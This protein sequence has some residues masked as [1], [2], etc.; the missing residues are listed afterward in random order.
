MFDLLTEYLNIVLV[1]TQEIVNKA[2]ADSHVFVGKAPVEAIG[3]FAASLVRHQR[4][5]ADDLLTYPFGFFRKAVV[6]RGRVAGQFSFTEAAYLAARDSR[7]ASAGEEAKNEK[8]MEKNS[9]PGGLFLLLVSW[10]IFRLQVP[11]FVDHSQHFDEIVGFDFVEN[12]VGV[13]A[14]FPH[15]VFIQFRHFASFAGQDVQADGFVHQL[16]T[17]AP[18]IEWGVLG[19]VIMNM[20]K[21]GFGV[22]RPLHHV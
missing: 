10:N 4:L 12:P 11:P 6:S 1:L 2:F 22:L 14:E 18:G 5:H 19:D 16:L 8:K 15:S 9:I 21:L 13:K 20:T 17:D 7:E 3:Q